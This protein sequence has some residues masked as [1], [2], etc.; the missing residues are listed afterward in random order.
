MFP[1]F[2]ALYQEALDFFVTI[3]ENFTASFFQKERLQLRTPK[4]S[5]A[6]QNRVMI[7]EK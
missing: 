6:P 1:Y 3:V 7:F 2:Q 5:F 4:W